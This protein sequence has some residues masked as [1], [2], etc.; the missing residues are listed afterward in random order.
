MGAMRSTD[1]VTATC[2]LHGGQFRILVSRLIT[3]G[4]EAAGLPP[5]V[6]AA[7]A[8]VPAGMRCVQHPTVAATGSCRTCGAYFCATCD[9][10]LPGGVHLCPT[11]AT[12]PNTALSPRRK[13]AM[14]AS[15]AIAVWC[16]IFLAVLFSG[17]LA[18][19]LRTAAD[20]QA[21]GVAFSLFL[22]VPSI[23]GLALGLGSID[24]RLNN[25]PPLWV[26]TIWNGV[27]VAIFLLLCIAGLMRR[28]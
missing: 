13:R 14:I 18:K 17:A 8:A 1:G 11:C 24:R 28:A 9:F 2:P 12:T 15:I 21:L 19:H 16:T 4:S 3:P 10:A 7:H 23:V 22:M 26:G 5:L 27:I 20:R 6:E 25:P